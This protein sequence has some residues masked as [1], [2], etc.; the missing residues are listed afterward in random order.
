MD[1]TEMAQI[2]RDAGCSRE[3]TERLLGLQTPGE[4]LTQLARHRAALLDK[5]HQGERAISCLDYLAYQIKRS[6]NG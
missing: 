5:V 6:R 4:L 2:L 1:P 3:E